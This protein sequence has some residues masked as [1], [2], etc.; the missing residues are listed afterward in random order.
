MDTNRFQRT[1]EK[2]EEPMADTIDVHDLT[3]EQVEALERLVKLFRE[4]AK[5]VKLTKEMQE[6]EFTLGSKDSNVIGRLTRE[7]IYEDR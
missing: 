6:D 5:L 2:G 4:Q 1:K 3:G 7:E